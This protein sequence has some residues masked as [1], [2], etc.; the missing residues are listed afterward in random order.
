MVSFTECGGVSEWFICRRPTCRRICHSMCGSCTGREPRN[1]RCNVS[2]NGC[3]P[4]GM[5]E[6]SVRRLDEV[7]VD[8]PEGEITREFSAISPFFGRSYKARISESGFVVSG[9]AQPRRR[10]PVSGV[11]NVAESGFS[12]KSISEDSSYQKRRY[13]GFAKKCGYRDT[14]NS[15]ISMKR[16][17]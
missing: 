3:I 15:S 2:G 17:L 4:D 5:R 16:H 14:E 11:W 10:G 12:S 6:E 1:H 13:P 8:N 7:A 9:L